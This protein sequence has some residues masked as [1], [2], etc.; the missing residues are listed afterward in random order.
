MFDPPA[1]RPDPV[2]LLR[3]QAETRVPELVPIRHGRMLASPFAFYRG[4]ALMMASDLAGTPS[5]GLRVQ[6]CGDAHLANFGLFASPERHLV[7]DINDF[8]ETLP[9]PWEWDVKRL[10][11]SLE[12]AGRNNGFTDVERRD[13]VLAVVRSYR[14]A[15]SGFAGM[16]NLAVWYAQYPIEE[17]RSRLDTSTRK[18]IEKRAGK[19]VAK[20]QSRDHLRAFARLVHIVDGEPRFNSQP[21]LLVPVEELFGGEVAPEVLQA[22]LVSAIRT[23]RSTLTTEYRKLLESYRFVQLA[24]KVVG[25]GSVGTRA[26]VALML[27]RDAS[28]PLLLQI[29][30]AQPSVLEAFVGRSEY[31]NAGH[32]VV[33]GQR[34][35]QAASDHLLGWQRLQGVDGRTRD[36][37]VRQLHDWKGSFEAEQMVPFGMG[38]YA[39]ICGW[40]LARAHARSGDRIAIAS[41]LG[42]K[43]TFDRAVA[44]FASLYADQNARD[45]AAL[46]TA[47]TEGRVQAQ[48]GV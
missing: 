10:A 45:H 7:F 25:V 11:A 15:M 36:F 12:I 47:V 23:Y 37:Y 16:G 18:V 8:D 31:S 34:L 5:T 48:S 41:Y 4:A 35:M 44:A 40:T 30:E 26:W 24:R 46:A 29:K 3:Q 6:L 9:G 14:T 1:T 28:D 22:A 21:P 33:A 13:I 20:A 32:R 43:D 39:E 2:E 19:V 17:L 27:G 38:L 42:S